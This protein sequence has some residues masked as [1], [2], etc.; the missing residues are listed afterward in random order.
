MTLRKSSRCVAPAALFL[1]VLATLGWGVLFASID[2]RSRLESRAPSLQIG[3]SARAAASPKT[4][5]PRRDSPRA[6]PV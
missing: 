2:A 1:A 4:V 6:V 5:A 3:M